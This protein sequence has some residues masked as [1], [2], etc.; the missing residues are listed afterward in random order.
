[1]K[2]VYTQNIFSLMG[3]EI[4]VTKQMIFVASFKTKEQQ[5]SINLIFGRSFGSLKSGAQR[6]I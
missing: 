3:T 2:I 6:R 5:N 1:M 4:E